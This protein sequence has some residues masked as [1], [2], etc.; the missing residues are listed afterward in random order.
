MSKSL[1]YW[2]KGRLRGEAAQ[3]EPTPMKVNL[4]ISDKNAAILIDGR[5]SIPAATVARHGRT[6]TSTAS[7]DR[8]S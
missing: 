4:L 2:L 8:S 1:R 5:R 7:L 6:P 3:D